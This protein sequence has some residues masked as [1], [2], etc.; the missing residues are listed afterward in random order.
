M[1]AF[2]VKYDDELLSSMLKAGEHADFNKVREMIAERLK[3]Q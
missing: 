2:E 1:G 3:K